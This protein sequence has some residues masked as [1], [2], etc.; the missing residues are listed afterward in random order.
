[1]RRGQPPGHRERGSSL[2]AGPAGCDDRINNLIPEPSC[3]AG[4][5]RDLCTESSAAVSLLRDSAGGM[6]KPRDFSLGQIF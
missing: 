6:N 5:A 1:M 4:T 2:G 3:G